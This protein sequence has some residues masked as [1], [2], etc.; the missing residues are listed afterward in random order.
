MR[1]RI[2]SYLWAALR[3][4]IPGA[5][6]FGVL[7]LVHVLVPWLIFGVG[8]MSILFVSIGYS[9]GHFAGQ[10]SIHPVEFVKRRKDR[11]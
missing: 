9:A 11:L 2:E 3:T 7:A 1:E 6:C 5:L 10:H 4:I 8:W